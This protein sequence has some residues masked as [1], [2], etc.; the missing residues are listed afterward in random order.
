MP[1]RRKSVRYTAVF[2]DGAT[3]PTTG[4]LLVD[5]ERLLL[6]GR[7][8]KS[9]V[10]LSISYAEL[11]EIRIGRNRDE[12]LNGRPALVL[13]RRNAPPVQV[14]PLGAGL[15]HELADLLA[16]LTARPSDTAEQVAVI[17]PLK[18][19]CMTQAKELVAQGPPFDPRALDLRRHEVVLTEREAIF[20]F[21]GPRVREKLERAVANPSLLR[22]G[23]AW[24]AC[25]AG[26]PRLESRRPAGA[27]ESIYEWVAEDRT[28]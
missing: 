21:V 16:T 17:V 4:G 24:R 12:C 20:V 26:R 5:E 14:Q 22:A 11:R 23:L 10:E 25:I 9:R 28:D 6:T 8:G 1:V 7:N 19:G 13:A 15:L 3:A 27:G 2:C 18:P